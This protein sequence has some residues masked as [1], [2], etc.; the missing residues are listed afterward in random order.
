[1]EASKVQDYEGLHKFISWKF[2]DFPQ[3]GAVG[4]Q[5][6]SLADIGLRTWS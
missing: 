6:V 4:R 2:E 1:M 3:R 5:G